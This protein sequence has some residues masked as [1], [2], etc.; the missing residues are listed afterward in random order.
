M[1][2]YL[3]IIALLASTSAF[4]W[5]TTDT[6]IAATAGA[7]TVTGGASLAAG[8]AGGDAVTSDALVEATTEAAADGSAETVENTVSSTS[9]SLASNAESDSENLASNVES[10]FKRSKSGTDITKT[11]VSAE[12]DAKHVKTTLK[13]VESGAKDVGNDVLALF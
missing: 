8:A 2:N 1:N 7:A 12:M 10:D 9:E 11:F 13:T 3:T 6:I 4:A 5:D